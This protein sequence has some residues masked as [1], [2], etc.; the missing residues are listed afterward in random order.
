MKKEVLKEKLWAEP[1]YKH[2]TPDQMER[3]VTLY[4]RE[5]MVDLMIAKKKAEIKAMIRQ[6]KNPGSPSPDGWEG[7]ILR[8]VQIPSC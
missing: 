6:K 4:R 7:L 1:R 3:L 8:L 5:K 2:L